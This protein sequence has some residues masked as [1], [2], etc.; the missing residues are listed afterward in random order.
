MPV[1]ASLTNTDVL[2]VNLPAPMPVPM[3]PV[4]PGA[5]RLLFDSGAQVHAFPLPC[6]ST[7]ESHRRG[8]GMLGRPVTLRDGGNAVHETK[9]V[10]TYSGKMH[11]Y[12]GAPIITILDCNVVPGACTRPE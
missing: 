4:A 7:T 1:V 8:D 6:L 9:G 3:P 5:R 11:M 10:F 12:D 2:T